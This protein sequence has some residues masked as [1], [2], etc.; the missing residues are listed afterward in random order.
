MALRTCL[1]VSV[2]LGGLAAGCGGPVEEVASSPQVGVAK[3]PLFSWLCDAPV[4]QRSDGTYAKL[5]DTGLYCSVA[6]DMMDKHAELF[7]PEVPLWT[8]GAD[9]SRYLRLPPGTKIETSDMDNWVFPVGTKVWKEFRFSG[10]KVE[11]RLLEKRGENNWFMVAFQWNADQTEAYP[12]PEGVVNANGTFHDIPSVSQCAAC[13]MRVADALIGVSPLML[14][15]ASVWGVTL[16]E[17]V[18]EGRLTKNPERPVRFPGNGPTSKALAYFYSNCSHCHRG[19]S[20]PE[21]LQLWTS[22][23][24]VRPEDTAVYRTAVNQDLTHWVEHGYVKRVVPKAPNE[25]GVMARMSTRVPDDQ[26]PEL[27]TERVDP[28]GLSLIR[29]WIEQLP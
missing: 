15:D 3:E 13:H 20:A 1:V 11:T 18:R 10:K 26:M 14:A 17:L 21:G 2:V 29:A 4:R 19:S 9:K 16:A 8:D 23:N 12:V 25:S 7:A 22:V 28:Q 6:L 27:G 24:D 5:S